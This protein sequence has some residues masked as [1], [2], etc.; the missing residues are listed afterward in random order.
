MSFTS[1]GLEGTDVEWGVL[2]L[3]IFVGGVGGVGGVGALGGVRVLRGVGNF[4][5]FFWR[6]VL[7]FSGYFCFGIDDFGIFDNGLIAGVVFLIVY[8]CCLVVFR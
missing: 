3:G 1:M 4:R 7:F 8:V 6:H 5:L 2:R